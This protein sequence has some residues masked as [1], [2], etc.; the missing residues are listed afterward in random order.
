MLFRSHKQDRCGLIKLNS[1]GFCQIKECDYGFTI[2]IPLQI[3]NVYKVHM[4]KPGNKKVIERNAELQKITEYLLSKY[5][6][7][8][9]ENLFEI[10]G[11]ITNRKLEYTDFMFIMNSRFHYFGDYIIFTG[12][13]QIQY[14]SLFREEDAL[15][16]L[17]QRNDSEEYRNLS[18]PIFTLQ[19]C[20]EAIKIGRAHV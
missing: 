15:H 6:V 10:L 7:I 12:D 19:H 11:F 1:Y 3:I 16:V 5:G 14:I 20:R 17:E 13:D 8:E 2:E 18:Y 9:L 4:M